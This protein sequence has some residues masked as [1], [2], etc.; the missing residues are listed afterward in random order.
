MGRLQQHIR[1]GFFH[2]EGAW[3]SLE[4]MVIPEVFA[5]AEPGASVW[6]WVVGCNYCE[7]AYSIAILLC[8]YIERHDQTARARIFATDEDEDAIIIARRG[9]YPA[10]VADEIGPVRLNRFFTVDQQEVV[11]KQEVRDMLL[12]AL[13]FIA[14]D[15]SQCLN[16]SKFNRF[17]IALHG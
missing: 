10:M 15:V 13:N 7:I 16:R 11:I 1:G 4:A 12:F 2:D 9:R 3:S 5:A 6:V 8:E 17:S 14:W